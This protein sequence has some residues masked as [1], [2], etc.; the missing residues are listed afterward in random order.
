MIETYLYVK[1]HTLTGKLYFGKT[2]KKD[3]YNYLGS[4]I[5]WLKHIRKHGKNH[6]VTKWISEPFTDKE[7]LVEF[8]LAFSDLF[9]IVNDPKWANLIPE[10]GL[11]GNFF[12]MSHS[13]E[14]REKMIVSRG[15]TG[16]KHTEDSKKKMSIVQKGRVVTA[17]H[18]L[19]ISKSSRSGD[20][21]VRDKISKS[22]TG[23]K[24]S[25]ELIEKRAAANR[26]P[27]GA[28]GK[29]EHCKYRIPLSCPHCSKL[30]N[31]GSMM[32]YHFDNCK[33]NMNK[34]NDNGSAS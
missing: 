20:Q 32:R 15:H 17:E 16:R 30:G 29:S 14:S 23:R 19:N 2:T 28:Y 1:E 31:G 21:E 26:K 11:D 27:R 5:Y 34:G 18:K 7:Q 24:Q 13:K 8:S 22:L 9:D 33:Y 12:G 4:G 25:P 6:V 10:N 3:Y